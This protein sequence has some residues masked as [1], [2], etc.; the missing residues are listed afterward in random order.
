[1]RIKFGLLQLKYAQHQGILVDIKDGLRVSCFSEKYKKSW[2]K[3][4]F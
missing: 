4:L 1:L 2:L 3:L